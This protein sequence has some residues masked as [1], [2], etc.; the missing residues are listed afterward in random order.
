MYILIAGDQEVNTSR[1]TIK[2]K[3]RRNFFFFQIDI[4]LTW[5]HLLKA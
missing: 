4:F 3:W 5:L 1:K 2:I